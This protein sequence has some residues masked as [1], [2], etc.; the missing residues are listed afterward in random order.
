MEGKKCAPYSDVL[1]N[2][3][4]SILMPEDKVVANASLQL[5]PSKQNYP[6]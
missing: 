5:K 1:K 3:L 6:T 4:G 2:G